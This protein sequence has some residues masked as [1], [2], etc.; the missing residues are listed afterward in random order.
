MVNYLVIFLL[1][2]V[3]II[4]PFELTPDGLTLKLRPYRWN[5]LANIVYIE[6]PAGVGFSYSDIG[7]YTHNDDSTARDN[8]DAIQSFFQLYPEYKTNKFYI[9]GESYAGNF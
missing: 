9:T 6:A 4:G 2:S 8:L 1:L 3:Y 7:H 5:R